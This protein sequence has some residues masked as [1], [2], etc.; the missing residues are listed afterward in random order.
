M[1]QSDKFSFVKNY[2]GA[3]KRVGAFLF[4]AFTLLSAADLCAGVLVAPTVVVM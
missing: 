2:A 1:K 4:V 3:W